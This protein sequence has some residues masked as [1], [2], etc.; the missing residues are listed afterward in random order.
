MNTFLF[1]KAVKEGFSNLHKKNEHIDK[2]ISDHPKLGKTL[3]YG[4]LIV[5]FFIIFLLNSMTPLS[6]D[7]FVY[8][9][10]YQ[11]PERLSSINDIVVS[12]YLHYF[13]WG[14]RSIVHFI[15]QLLLL[16]NSPFC[17][18]FINSLAFVALIYVIYKHIVG[19]KKYSIS[20]L[21][22][23]FFLVWTLQ[24]TFAETVLWITGS[25][26]YLWGTLIIL[27]FLFPYRFNTG[28]IP[29]K[30]KSVWASVV[31]LVGGVVAGWTN[32]NTAAGMIVIILMCIVYYKYK[33][34][35]MSLWVYTGLIGAVIGYLIMIAAPGNFARAEGTSISPFLVTYRVLMATQNFVNYLGILNLGGA[36]LL[37]LHLKLSDNGAKRQILPYIG[38][39][40]IGLL[41]SIYIMAGSP[42]FPPR[43][44][45]GPIIFNIIIFGIILFNL[46]YTH[47]FFRQIQSCIVLFGVVSFSFSFYDAY[48]DVSAI[49]SIWKERFPK[50]EQSKKEN[51]TSVTFKQYNAKTK[52][53]LGDAPYAQK[54]ISQYY[55]IEFELEN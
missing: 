8:S 40:F 20:I 9:F 47:S 46:D 3:F 48:N 43:T 37:I 15:A 49:N 12:Q 35:D 4:L 34:Y 41:I 53:G 18:D 17:I 13:Q 39:Y 28:K 38:I 1:S 25:A 30:T 55:G 31:M 2:Y 22:I 10:V 26:N 52:F 24:P 45:F 19:Q 23:V 21:F 50:I 44:W 33:K 27:L 14:G 36:I 7:D 6:G 51:A 42:G 11:T 29:T 32:E 5:L 16:T 54:Y